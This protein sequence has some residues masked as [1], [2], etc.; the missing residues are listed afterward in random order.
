MK[1]FLSSLP[2]TIK[3]LWITFLAGIVIVIFYVFA[4]ATNL[5]GL[6]GKIPSLRILENPRT[7]VASEMYAA[8][9]LVLGK[10]FRSNR[11]P[12]PYDSISKKVI[13]T[14]LA[15]EDI[16]FYD[17]HG[18]DLTGTLSIVWYL[19]KGDKRGASTITQQLAKNLFKTRQK[20]A[21]G[22]L[23]GVPGLGKVI[24]KTKEWITSIRLERSYTK[25]EIMTMYLNTV[26]FGSNSF[27]IKVAAQTFFGKPQSQL[28]WEEAA[29]LIGLL[30]APTRYS[31]VLHPQRAL[32]RRNTILDQL[33]KY[34]F[35]NSDSILRIRND[36]IQL[37][38]NVENQNQGIA[39]YFRSI[40]SRYLRNWCKNNGFDLYSDGLKIYTTIDSKMQIYAEKSMASHLTYLQRAFL[41]EWGDYKPW[42]GDEHK[43]RLTE[44]SLHN[45]K[46]VW[47]QIKR[48]DF[49]RQI[50]K[51]YG[52]DTL[53]IQ[54]ELITPQKLNVFT[55][56]GSVDTV[57]TPLQR[58]AHHLRFLQ[59]GFMSMEPLTGN[60][61]AWVGG[62]DYRH[63]KYDHVKQG[64][65]QPGSSFKPM[66]YATAFEEAGDVYS[67]CYKAVDQPVTFVVGSGRKD[68]LHL[69]KKEDNKEREEKKD[70]DAVE[71]NIWTPKNS[72]N[73]FSGD[74]LTLRQALARSINSITALMMKSLGDRTPNEVL[75]FARQLGFTS[76]IAAVPAM[77]LGVFDVSVYEMVGA[78]SAFL[79]KG[80]WIEPTYISRIEDKF[81]NVLMKFT[82]ERRKVLSEETAYL[83]LYMLQGGVQEKGGTG[84]GI[85]SYGI[86]VG[87]DIG[88]KTGTTQNSSDGWFMCVTPDLV[89]GCWVGGDHRLIRFQSKY[90]GQGARM[91]M[92]IIGQYLK[93]VYADKTLGYERKKFERPANLSVSLNCS[94]NT[95]PKEGLTEG[96]SQQ[97]FSIENSFDDDLD[98]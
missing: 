77:S 71:G 26:D 3:L 50:K 45:D 15:T 90:L 7:E 14:L 12:I 60:I 86:T 37:H 44:K 87:N 67:P 29:V 19:I 84:M 59:T 17:H 10:Y 48:T 43:E 89:S 46:V 58:V 6:S 39:P 93:D 56:K 61:K 40:A 4:V 21:K 11:T 79:N 8:D 20:E 30:K 31:P 73:K 78:Y 63:F 69:N 28:K 92:P 35:V 38:Y 24:M 66:V 22:T 55:W 25:K 75:K 82:P 85:H 1:H 76:E 36:S 52:N 97:T 83:M 64:K 70:E 51:K 74:T 18:I 9:G 94:S 23:T 80:T 32:F 34:E 98:Q 42:A 27:G 65:R 91:A 53:A 49:Y 2:T 72:N 62:I 41:R 88:T 54:K 57:M 81:G 68:I 33:A 13:N 16:R 95:N 47:N 5:G 96:E